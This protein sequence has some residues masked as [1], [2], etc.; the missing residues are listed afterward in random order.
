M[1]KIL[2]NSIVNIPNTSTHESIFVVEVLS[3]EPKDQNDVEV[4][5]LSDLLEQ[6]KN[7]EMLEK[8]QSKPAS[9]SNVYSP[10][11]EL[12]IFT[13]LFNNAINNHKRIH[14]VW[15]TLKEEIEMLENYYH[16]LW[17]FNNDINC[18]TCDFSKAL[19]TVSC[20]IENIMWRG[21][22]YKRMWKEI[23]FNPPIRESW[24]VKA[25]FKWIN[26]WV[27]AWIYINTQIRDNISVVPTRIQNFLQ[28]QIIEE[29]ILALTLWRVLKYNL[30]E[31]WIIGKTLEI[32]SQ[33]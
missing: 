25:L 12:E 16:E 30:D 6:R 19:V 32:K 11:D 24:Q 7:H 29:N 27:I 5:F 22:D 1:K 4:I 21:S 9:Y 18:Y 26:R 23:F 10:K 33:Y 20:K 3:W 8:A 28:Q 13:E 31:V 14:I 17:F 15:V 2:K